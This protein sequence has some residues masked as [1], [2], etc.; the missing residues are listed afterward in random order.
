V[1]VALPPLRDYDEL[2]GSAEAPAT[3]GDQL[4]EVAA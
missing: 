1:H 2:I 4:D 3:S